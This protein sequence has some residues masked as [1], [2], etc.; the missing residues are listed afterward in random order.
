MNCANCGAAMELIESR[1]YFFCRH[2][3]SFHFPEPADRDGIRI[4]GNVADAPPCPVCRELL[5][6]ALLDDAHPVHFCPTCRGVLMPR[7]TFAGVVNIRRAWAANPPVEPRLL[8]RQALDR[9][10]S[11]PSCRGRFTTHPYYGPG[12]VV[13]DSCDSCD[14]VW[15]DFGELR[16]IVDAPGRDRGGR[17]RALGDDLHIPRSIE[18]DQDLL[19]AKD[20]LDFLF[21]LLA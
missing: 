21:D 7:Q 17:N 2:C 9:K 11:C 20:P 19:A 10:L 15:L 14:I 12:N 4:V 3:G 13:M 5:V 16:Q 18:Q 6:Q 8:D 1:R